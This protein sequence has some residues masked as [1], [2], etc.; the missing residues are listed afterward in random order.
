MYRGWHELEAT[1]GPDKGLVLDFDMAAADVEGTPFPERRAVLAELVQLVEA[2]REFLPG[3]RLHADPSGPCNPAVLHARLA[4]SACYLR[5]LMG[6]RR[7]FSALLTEQMAVVPHTLSADERASAHRTLVAALEA[8]GIAWSE[9]GATELAMQYRREG[10]IAELAT[11]LRESAEQF[12]VALQE[13]IPG[14][15]APVYA[16]RV[17]HEDAYWCNWIDG[18]RD[19]GVLLQINTHPRSSYQVTSHLE[20]AAHEIAGHA[21]HVGALVDS[22]EQGIVDDCMLNLTVHACEAVQMEGLAQGV[23]EWLGPDAGGASSEDVVALSVLGMLRTWSQRHLDEAH[24][25]LE[26]GASLHAVWAALSR[27]LPLAGDAGWQA[28]LTDRM[29][30]PLHRAYLPAYGPGHRLIRSF[31]RL[32]Q[33]LRRR[34]W[35]AVYTELWTPGQLELLGDGVAPELVRRQ[36]PAPPRV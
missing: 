12:I 13:R 18:N 26:A 22:A 3:E 21:A 33:P 4:G 5:A 29:R 8:T 7:P 25:R 9:Q 19:N 30:S 1:L 23:L 27:A 6:E 28:E 20:L 36:N 15:R 35:R 17:V 34:A 31:S 32:P 2:A 11:A 16:V 10:S 24:Q 14:L